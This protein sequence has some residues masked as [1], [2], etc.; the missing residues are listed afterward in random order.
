MGAGHLPLRTRR[1]DHGYGVGCRR[2]FAS[3]DSSLHRL[4]CR[5]IPRPLLQL[6]RGHLTCAYGSQSALPIASWPRQCRKH[7]IIALQTAPAAGLGGM[8]D[9]RQRII[10]RQTT[11]ATR[12]TRERVGVRLTATSRT[13]LICNEVIQ[14]AGSSPR[15]KPACR[16]LRV[17]M[18]MAS[19]LCFRERRGLDSAG[20]AG[21]RP[22]K[23]RQPPDQDVRIMNERA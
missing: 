18:L 2:H 3:M 21:R 20:K 13:R 4:A 17:G 19:Q 11:G 7:P 14:R 9:P 1:L 22:C 10:R 6:R 23:L 15:I 16:G 5:N 8:H 12:R